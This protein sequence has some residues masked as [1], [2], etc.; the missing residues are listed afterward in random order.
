MFNSKILF[1]KFRHSYPVPLFVVDVGA[2]YELN[3]SS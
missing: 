1:E 3:F 2:G